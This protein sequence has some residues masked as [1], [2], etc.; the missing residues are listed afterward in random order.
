MKWT[1][2]TQATVRII[3]S[4]FGAGKYQ[5][6]LQQGSNTISAEAGEGAAPPT[7]SDRMRDCTPRCRSS[8]RAAG[9]GARRPAAGD[10]IGAP[11]HV[12]DLHRPAASER[13]QIC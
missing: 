5:R 8:S 9:G 11:V 1:I 4:S 3:V 13:S 2:L 7:P 10:E 6:R 12:Q